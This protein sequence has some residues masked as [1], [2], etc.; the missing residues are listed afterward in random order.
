MFLRMN[1]QISA[2][3]KARLTKFGMQVQVNQHFKKG[4]LY[5]RNHAHRPLNALGQ[6]LNSICKQHVKD[7][8]FSF[9]MYL[10]DYII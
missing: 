3:I 9:D 4:T 6:S 1:V 5:L 2:I 8:T 7:T 10:A